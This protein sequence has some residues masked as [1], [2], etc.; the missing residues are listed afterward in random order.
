MAQ[1]KE[2]ITNYP[3]ISTQKLALSNLKARVRELEGEV[4]DQ[5]HEL[6]KLKLFKQNERPLPLIRQDLQE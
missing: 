2:Q 6:A 4:G 5:E 3:N 1:E